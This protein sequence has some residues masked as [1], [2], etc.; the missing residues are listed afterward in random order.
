M[1]A[2]SEGGYYIVIHE[3]VKRLIS[4]RMRRWAWRKV[5]TYGFPDTILISDI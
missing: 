3:G 5:W 1:K 2:E 4:L